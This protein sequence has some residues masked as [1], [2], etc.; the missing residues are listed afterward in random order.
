[1]NL[2]TEQYGETIDYRIQNKNKAI[3]DNKINE[4]NQRDKYMN[5]YSRI[6]SLEHDDPS[7]LMR[8]GT[9]K[10]QKVQT[11][12]F[13]SI[14]RNSMRENDMAT[15]RIPKF[16]ESTQDKKSNTKT[17]DSKNKPKNDSKGEDKYIDNNKDS[18]DEITDM[19][20]SVPDSSSKD[21]GGI[22]LTELINLD[23]NADLV[24]NID[25]FDSNNPFFDNESGQELDK[26][27]VEDDNDNNEDNME[28]DD[29]NTDTEKDNA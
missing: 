21:A 29:E 28:D 5:M 10:R 27:V 20:S 1:M 19:L 8:T 4:E 25:P 17:I 22:D 18:L 26:Y 12:S 6:E 15:I 11:S 9:G 16:K 23:E 24:P 13:L 3:H 2:M 14:L 7:I